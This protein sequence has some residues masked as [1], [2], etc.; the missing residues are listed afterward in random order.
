MN[1]QLGDII[2]FKGKGLGY[3]ILSR[4]LKLFERDY[5]R[6]G[7][8]VGVVSKVREN[9]VTSIIEAVAPT[10]RESV[11]TSER[12]YRVYRWLDHPITDTIVHSFVEGHRGMRYDILIYFWTSVAVI[13]RHF[14]NRPIP[15]LLDRLFSCWELAQ[16]FMEYVGKPI[17]SKYDVI[18]ISDLLKVLKASQL[19]K[20]TLIGEQHIDRPGI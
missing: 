2:V 15:K 16:D 18:I 1:L 5:V 11:L 3:Q 6:W 8:H 9:G 4:L 14:W 13:V 7:W 10:V 20:E 17:V 19:L 12:P